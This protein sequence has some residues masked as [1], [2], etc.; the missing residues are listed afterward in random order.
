MDWPVDVQAFAAEL[1]L[2]RFAV[3]GVS[4]GGPY[5]LA[6]ARQLPAKMLS[7]VGVLAGAPLWDHGV[8][9]KGIPW[10]ARLTYLMGNYWPSVLKFL[11]AILVTL[12]RWI[13][14]TRLVE[15]RIDRTL[16]A[17]T[18]A[19]VARSKNTKAYDRWEEEATPLV[20]ET[21]VK[22]DKD[23]SEPLPSIK[24][25][26]ER[27]VAL[28]F[29]G[30]TQGTSG[31]VQETQLLTRDWGFRFED[32]EYDQVQIW[33]GLRDMNAPVG[34]IR[35]MSRRMPHCILKEYDDNHFSIGDHFEEVLDEIV[36]R[37]DPTMIGRT[38]DD[39]IERLSRNEGEILTRGR[40]SSVGA[41]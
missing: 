8:W 36:T 18:K 4:G 23:L 5:A 11:S 37:F 27:L 19:E 41:R 22:Q 29:E 17:M 35:N 39:R 3:L 12:A 38:T 13:M 1:G 9:T 14:T 21:N 2:S 26:R 15:E 34:S 30:F 40:S 28:I 6:C 25:R 16:V 20:T 7:A 33:H 31:F 24:E 32:I 10:Y